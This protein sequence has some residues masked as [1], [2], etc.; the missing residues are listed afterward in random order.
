MLIIFGGLPGVGKT[1]IARELARAIEALH[2]RIIRSSKL[3]APPGSRISRSTTRGTASHMRLRKTTCALA[4][5]SLPI[6]SIR[7][8]TRDAWVSVANRAGVRAFEIEVTCS[9]VNEHRRRVEMRTSDIPGLRLPTWEE[10][11]AR[12]Y[13]P[14]NREHLVIDTAGRTVEQNVVTVRRAFILPKF[15]TTPIVR[16]GESR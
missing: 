9:D 8:L 5:S 16:G 11:I 13:H 1:A 7:S 10:V 14:W 4:G 6:R 15:L 2:L 12:D 3:S